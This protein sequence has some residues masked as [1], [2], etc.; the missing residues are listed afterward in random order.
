MSI[1]IEDILVFS[2]TWEEHLHHLKLVLER[3]REVNLKLKLVKCR[4][5]RQ[6]VQYLGYVVTPKGL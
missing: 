5:L 1:Y 6:E 4:F 2:T 3:L